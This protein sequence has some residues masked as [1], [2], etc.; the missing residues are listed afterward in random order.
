M[1]TTSDS[2]GTASRCPA[3]TS[4]QASEVIGNTG[5]ALTHVSH[6]LDILDTSID[7]TTES[8][9][10]LLVRRP[11]LSSVFYSISLVVCRAETIYQ[12]IAILSSAIWSNDI[13][14]YVVAQYIAIILALLTSKDHVFPLKT[15]IIFCFYMKTK[16]TKSPHLTL[17]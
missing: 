4:L 17:S 16:D 13:C 7:P 6:I 15:L 14:Q 1:H 9:C 12:Y 11:P 5:T 8:R 10:S 2:L 3:L